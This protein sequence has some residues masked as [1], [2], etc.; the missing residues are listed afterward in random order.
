M[1][2]GPLTFLAPLA[3]FGL[4]A[5]PII[6]WVLKITPPKPLLQIFP[7]LRLLADIGKEEDTPNATPIWLLLFR[8]LMGALLAVALAKPILFKPDVE[9]NRPLAL[10]I[11]N[12]WAAAGNWS[13]VIGEAEALAALAVSEN[14][15]VAVLRSV[16]I[17]GENAAGFIPATEALKSVRSLQL[18]SYEPERIKLADQ[19]ASMDLSGADILWLSDGVDYGTAKDFK[20]TLKSGGSQKI[21]RPASALSPLLAGKIEETANGFRAA[22]HRV[23]TQSLR[24]QNIVAFS[25]Q[26]RVLARAEIKFMPGEAKAE[27]EFE[28]PAELRNRV[29]L[30]K[31]EGFSSA[32]SVKLLDDSWGRPLVGLLKGSDANTQPL[33]SEWHYIEEALKPSADIYRGDLDELLAVS[34]GIIFMSDRARSESPLLV[35]YVEDGG[36][37]VRFAGPKLAKRSDKLL[38]VRLRAGGR[39]IGGALAW[40]EPQGFASFAEDSPF[41]GLSVREDIVVRKQVLATPGADTDANTWARLADG[42][43]VITSSVRGL[44]RVVLFHVTAGPDWSTLPLS[45]LYVQMLDRLLPL[46]RSTSSPIT[47]ASSGD[48]TAERTLDGYGNLGT[49]PLTAGAI[50]D[51]VFTKTKPGRDHPPGLYRQGLRR[52]ALNTVSNPDDYT[53]LSASGMDKAAYGGRKPKSLSG[54]L[55][56]VLALMMALDV[57]MSLLASGR[58]RGQMWQSTAALLLGAMLFLPIDATAQENAQ[59][60]AQNDALGLHLAYVITG[61]S[62]VDRLSK[63][64]LEGLVFAL[65]RRTTIEPVGVRGV[66]I[67]KDGVDFYPF[68]YWPVLRDAKALSSETAAKLNAFM[69]AGGT[70]VL[71][72]QDQD[73]KQLFADET[74]PGLA[75]LSEN[76]DIP[77]LS[78]PSKTHVITKSFYLIKDYPGRWADGAVWV[79]ADTRGSSRDGVSSVIVGSNDWAAAWARD[80]KGRSLSVIENEIPRQ[81]EMATRFGINLT[82]YALSGNYKGDQVHATKIVERLGEGLNGAIAPEAP[83]TEFGPL[84]EPEIEGTEQ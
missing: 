45:G 20:D 57:V 78:A 82:M 55:L 52:Q 28:L 39:D 65:A 79:E 50:G 31:P 43:P 47:N 83:E 58:L 75:R 21:Y 4:L 84:F 29:S 56:G 32:G 41:F 60:D 69:Q 46:A 10:I 2:I 53:L 74:H 18:T 66:D 72:T 6:W 73:R 64:G 59:N 24:N 8:L 1:V 36:M 40:E 80:D 62:E 61:N 71:D 48:W 63:A 34:P 51:A 54:I 22:W 26:G 12:G 68:L 37:L 27:A 16:D 33:L 5:L 42:S 25:P 49:P 77:R 30:L 23:D 81:R 7:P 19:M 14:Q 76:L 3:L 15:M 70:L 67:T 17:R 38:P 35:K 44:G 13:A 9:T 11:D